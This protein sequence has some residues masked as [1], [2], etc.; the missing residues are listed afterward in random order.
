MRNKS[1]ETQRM[2][3]FS[4][5]S[6]DWEGIIN[7]CMDADGEQSVEI[8]K[9]L[10]DIVG[11]DKR[12]IA[13]GGAS[14]YEFVVHYPRPKLH[15]G[16]AKPQWMPI[17]AIMALIDARKPK[18]IL[19]MSASVDRFKVTQAA[20][21]WDAE[22]TL[23]NSKKLNIWEKFCAG[24][25]EQTPEIDYQTITMQELEDETDSRLFDFIF[26]WTN[27]LE[28]P[29]STVDVYIDKLSSGGILAI[30]NASDSM[31]LYQN[32]TATSPTYEM[33]AGIKHRKDCTV[34]HIPIFYGIT[35][36][37]KD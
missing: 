24:K 30:Q 23:V 5:F 35:I 19:F 13:T 33:H 29:L 36:V 20:Q 9:Y 26:G 17:L 34:Y 37:V 3:E 6:G 21:N 12:N 4:S 22:I 31:F 18:S 10:F 15:D 2:F 8:G 28:N 27:E 1:L 25:H 7:S 16:Y 14:D 11:V 32:D